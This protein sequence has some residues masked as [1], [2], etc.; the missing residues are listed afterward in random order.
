M[1]KSGRSDTRR[2]VT[3][4]IRAFREFAESCVHWL[5]NL[6]CPGWAAVPRGFLIQHKFRNSFI[7]LIRYLIR[8]LIY[9]SLIGYETSRQTLTV[10]IKLFCQFISQLWNCSANTLPLWLHGR[11]KRR[12]TYKRNVRRVHVTVVCRGRTISITYSECV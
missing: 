9:L 5:N 6:T 12:C 3:K 10:N 8:N 4:V 2:D 1:R 11:Q 7:T